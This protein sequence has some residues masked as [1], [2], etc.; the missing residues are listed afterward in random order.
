M[1]VRFHGTADSTDSGV[2]AQA[3]A[4]RGRF[5]PVRGLPGRLC[6]LESPT[7]RPIMFYLYVTAP[8]MAARKVSLDRPV[9]TI[10]RSSMNDLPISDKML[11][12]QHSAHRA[13]RRRR[14]D[15]RGPRLAQRHVPERRAAHDRPGP[16]ARR[17]DHDRRRDAQGRVRIDDP[18]AHRGRRGRPARQHDP[19]GLGRTAA[20]ARAPRRTRGL[21]AEQLGKLDRVPAGRQRA[22]G[23]AAARHLGRRAARL[24]HGQGLRDAEARP[25]P[26]AAQV[27]RS[28]ASSR[29]RSCASA[30]GISAEDIR[31]SKTLVAAVVEKRNGLL[32]MD[33]ADGRRA[34]RWPIRSACPGSS[35][36]SRRRSRTTARSSA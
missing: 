26:R 30:E 13:L 14:P 19:Q 12:R 1:D 35:P 33:T 15:G 17:P 11:S 4:R 2:R 8:G 36:C 31:L 29:P 10:G 23:R 16:E 7:L 28:P 5:R 22:D 18:R 27:A 6:G 9:T 3:P 32:L 20:G 21:P 24:P 25:R 34:S